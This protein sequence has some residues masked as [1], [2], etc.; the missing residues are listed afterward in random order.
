MAIQFRH[1]PEIARD[2]DLILGATFGFAAASVAEALKKP[3]GYMAYCPQ[4]LQSSHHPAL[5]VKSHRHS[6]ETKRY[7]ERQYTDI[8]F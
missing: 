2:A 5:F 7:S 8:L 1:L 3:F 4:V 6:H